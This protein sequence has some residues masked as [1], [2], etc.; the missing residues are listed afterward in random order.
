MS[1]NPQ[2][3]PE[4]QEIDLSQISKK[5]SDFFDSILGSIF[6]VILFFK[7]N[8][9]IFLALFI[10]GAGIGYFLDTD[11]NYNSQIIVSP[12]GGGVDYLYSKIDL[13]KSKLSEQDYPFFKSIGVDNP[14]NIKNIKIEPI[15]DLYNFV[16]VNSG[17]I[18]KDETSQNFEVIK[19]LAESNDINQV[20]KDELTSKNYPYHS[21][22][23]SSN[24]KIEVN[25][26]I[27]PL[28]RFLN[29]DE[30]LNQISKINKENVL[31][32]MK[33]NEEEI[34]Q[35]DSLV[36]V[37]TKNISQNNK[38]SNLIYNNENNQMNEMFDLKNR[39]IN[40]IASQK[41]Q[42]VKIDSFIKDV[43]ITTN[44]INDK[45]IHNKMK[46]ILPL[47][48]CFMFIVVSIFKSFYR[49]QLAKSKA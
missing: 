40:E 42:L 34:I 23:I 12:S 9:L 35:L 14:E 18:S 6:N 3:N 11:K 39:L 26:I 37:I 21:I 22:E 1:S 28:L 7:R 36:N 44:I 4:N 48:L 30:Y 32:K 20:I 24:G 5:I 31:I 25:K 47:I 43:S 29:T 8:L 46:F 17:T 16:N 45:G 10:L 27:K 41:I 38:S 49:K 13:I 2:I 33:K 15:I 19:L